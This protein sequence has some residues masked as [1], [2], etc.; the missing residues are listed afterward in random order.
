MASIFDYQFNVGGNFTA[1]MDGMAESTATSLW[2]KSEKKNSLFVLGIIE[3][4][5]FNKKVKKKY[6]Y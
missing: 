1:A 5:L 6:F 4:N 3:I 2:V